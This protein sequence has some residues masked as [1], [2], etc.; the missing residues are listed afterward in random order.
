MK[1]KFANDKMYYFFSQENQCKIPNH[2]ILQVDIRL[3]LV[4]ILLLILQCL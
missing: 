2:E 4:L 3:T 1:L